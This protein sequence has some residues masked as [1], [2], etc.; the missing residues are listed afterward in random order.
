MA[1]TVPD[2]SDFRVLHLQVLLHVRRLQRELHHVLVVG[3]EVEA[4]V[5][6]V[7]NGD[8]AH[9]L[10]YSE[11]R[12]FAVFPAHHVRL[13]P[14][15]HGLADAVAEVKVG[16]AEALAAV[17]QLVL[18]PDV[19]DRVRVERAVHA[20]AVV[21]QRG[22]L[23]HRLRALAG[24][25]LVRAGLVDDHRPEALV[26]FLQRLSGEP[27]GRVMVGHIDVGGAGES[28]F[29]VLRESRTDDELGGELAQ[30][31]G[32]GVADERARTD[33]KDG[34]VVGPDAR[35]YDFDPAAGLAGAGIRAVE[36]AL[37]APAE[38]NRLLLML[39]QGF[40]VAH[41]SVSEGRVGRCGT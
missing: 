6:V 1:V 2:S 21:E 27:F 8:V 3:R 30:V 15:L 36:D 29:A 28:L 22:D 20:H 7:A 37:F 25:V 4:V 23:G 35:A 41:V 26:E 18:V 14:H 16:L 33:H 39:V 19:E 32:P 38:V 9:E 13:R 12:A 17:K 40:R 10:G 5:P 34:L 31:V 11:L 24:V